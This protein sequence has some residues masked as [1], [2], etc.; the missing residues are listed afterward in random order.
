MK[1]VSGKKMGEIDGEAISR[2]GIPGLILMENAGLRVVQLIQELRPDGKQGRV[3]IFCG[4]GNNGGDGFVIARHLRRLGYRVTT[5]ALD[6]ADAYK[7]DAAVNYQILLQQ[8]EEVLKMKEGNPLAFIEDLGAGDL[9]VDAL[10]GTGLGRPVEGLLAEVIAALNDSAAQI[11]S[12]DI[13]SGVSADTGE[14][15]G[16]A[17]QAHYTVTFALPKRGLLLFPGAAHTGRLIVADIGMP[18]ELAAATELRENL[19]TGP[20]VQ[21]HLPDRVADGHKGTYGRAFILAGSPGMTGAAALAGESALRGGAGLVYVGTAEELRPVL[22]AKLKEVITWGF[23]GDGRGNLVAE[24]SGMI[25]QYAGVCQAMAFGPGLQPTPDTLRLLKNLCGEIT[26]PLVVD[27]GGLGALALEPQFLKQ[28]AG[29]TPLILTPHPGEMARL[30]GDSA[31]GVQ[32]Q[33]WELAVEKAREWQAV[34]VLKGAHTVIAR[35]DGELY[36]NPTGNPL[37]STAGT[38]DLLTGLITALVAQGLEAAEAS[39]CGAYL[40]G[41][42]ADLLVENSG[43]RGFIAGDILDYI[44]AAFNKVLAL[45]PAEPHAPHHYVRG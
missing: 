29:K 45:P 26:V 24:G 27:A 39:L 31:S 12:A 11:I 16:I 36:L 42:A 7:G 3:A 44:P 25:M 13:P 4:R 20:F 10:L 34:V 5:W 14:I 9:I 15:L 41:L 35:P 19:I 8:G 40:H 22:E 30:V 28:S 23:P 17:V 18:A 1:I 43:P 6:R 37:L 2:F 21:A 32:Q 38:G 33:R